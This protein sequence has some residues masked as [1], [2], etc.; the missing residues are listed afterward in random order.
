MS[1]PPASY[2]DSG[3]SLI[4]LPEPESRRSPPVA[5]TR[6]VTP[7]KRRSDA[8]PPPPHNRHAHGN[9]TSASSQRRS[10]ASSPKIQ[11]PKS[12]SRRETPAID[13]PL[14][15]HKVL[16]G[17]SGPTFKQQSS[18]GSI[19]KVEGATV[20]PSEAS[21]IA[22]EE[23]RKQQAYER[24]NPTRSSSAQQVSSTATPSS[25]S[26]SA[27]S[28]YTNY[29]DLTE[30]AATHKQGNHLST[31]NESAPKASSSSSSSSSHKNNRI[32]GDR[33]LPPLRPAQTPNQDK[34]GTNIWEFD[35]PSAKSGCCI[36]M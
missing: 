15:S 1:D 30:S 24:E 3:P 22:T 18:G 35:T 28:R 7:P 14:A 8:P 21:L 11:L 23:A 2:Y 17:T 29:S 13:K 31:T 9:G 26:A 32:R 25:P 33:P 19:L 4:R 6:P 12:P 27:R 10:E 36:V 20:Q 5:A 34:S 16:S